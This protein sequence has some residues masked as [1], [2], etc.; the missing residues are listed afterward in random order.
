MIRNEITTRVHILTFILR[1][2][3]RQ[4]SACPDGADMDCLNANCIL[5]TTKFEKERC[6]SMTKKKSRQKFSGERPYPWRLSC[7]SFV[8]YTCWEK[9]KA[10]IICH[11]LFLFALLVCQ[12]V[13]SI[14]SFFSF[15]IIFLCKLPNSPLKA[16][17]N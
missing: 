6:V 2:L 8:L 3:H 4:K 11:F 16:V 10:I 17:V 12:C 7:I 5:E 1:N 9:K 15:C 14:L 13:L